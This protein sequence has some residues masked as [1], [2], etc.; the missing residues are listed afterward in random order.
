MVPTAKRGTGKLWRASGLL[1]AKSF[2]KDFPVEADLIKQSLCA[3]GR[4]YCIYDSQ[5]GSSCAATWGSHMILGKGDRTPVPNILLLTG[6]VTQ[7]SR[8]EVEHCVYALQYCEMLTIDSNIPRFQDDSVLQMHCRGQQM[9]ILNHQ[10]WPSQ[11]HVAGDPEL[12][13]HIN[14]PN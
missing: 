1:W 5:G 12:T 7:P 8:V 3:L 9:L 10:L 11:Q 6:T 2:N 4:I 13:R 14:Q